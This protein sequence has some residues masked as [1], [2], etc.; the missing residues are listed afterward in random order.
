MD[1]YAYFLQ[2]L[3]ALYEA[4]LDSKWIARAKDLANAM[5]AE[6]WDEKEG[7]FFLSGQS[8]EQL[9]SKLKNPADEALPSANAV[10]ALVLLQLG[11][12]TGEE[13]YTQKVEKTLQ[14]SAKFR[15]LH[16]TRGT[17]FGGG[18]TPLNDVFL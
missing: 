3:L 18:K 16:L 5:I 2:G 10:A 6:F 13:T 14:K 9:I 1:D 12:L 11:R 17:Q 8:G 7:G 15:E 4:G